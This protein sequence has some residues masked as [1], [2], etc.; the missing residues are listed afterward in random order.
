MLP[1]FARN[2]IFLI[3]WLGIG[4]GFQS[5]RTYYYAHENFN[6][7]F[8]SG[9]FKESED[10][11]NSHEPRK[12]A[13][14]KLLYY[15]N[16]GLVQFLQNETELANVSFEKAFLLIEDYESKPGE[17]V[18][19]FLTN[20][21]R[22]TYTGE[23]HERL[24]LSYFRALNQLKT[25]NYENVLVEARRLIG[26]LNVL[27]DG[28]KNKTYHTDGF[29]LWMVGMLFET[30]GES[31]NAYIYYK[32]AH[33]AYN[34]SF[35]GLCKI[36]EPEQ[37]KKDLVRTAIA[38]GFDSEAQQFQN[39]LHIMN[40]PPTKGEG[41]AVILWHKGLGPV[42][43]EDRIT[44]HMVKGSGGAITFTNEEFGLSF[45][46][47]W[48]AYE[49]PDPKRLDNIQFVTLALPKYVSRHTFW[50]KMNVS[51]N[52]KSFEFEPANN[53]S[54]IAKADLK[55]RF[56][57]TLAT[58]IGRVALKEAI[59]V[60]ATKA[61]EAAVQNDNKKD[62]KE[63]KQKKK[64]QADLAGSLVNLALMISNAATE[65]ADTRN[66]Q[67][68]PDQIEVLRLN[69]PAGKQIL[70]LN[71]TGASGKTFTQTIDLEIVEGQSVFHS[72]Q[73]F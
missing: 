20:P 64:D 26:R 53:L 56:A 9:R 47:I 29:M 52:G 42:K 36:K 6:K 33:E 27:E 44:F 1:L 32:K 18:A 60:A 41:T 12:K 62:S 57:A 65:R 21:N 40:S 69:L 7:A 4:T 55:D 14:D 39:Q 17:Y 72:V 28:Y 58:A 23:R 59:R 49:Q 10:W 15:S 19:S 11:L 45:P 71:V 46:M 43:D 50:N 37:L 24:L 51:T 34:L 54:E 66:W 67:T 48:P 22:I 68:T 16:L 73:T 8:H 31:N 13:K 63:Q 5:C 70:T 61:T 2:L 30:A 25:N 38:A 3:L 35:A